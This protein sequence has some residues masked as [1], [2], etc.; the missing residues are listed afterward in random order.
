MDK[1]DMGESRIKKVFLI[2]DSIRIGYQPFVKKNLKDITEVL[3]PEENCETSLKIL[4]NLEN[5]IDNHEFDIV[6]INC[7]LHDIKVEKERGINFIPI[8]SYIENL[9]KIFEFLK[10][11]SNVIIWAKMKTLTIELNRFIDFRKIL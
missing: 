6:H 4:K 11:K 1:S 3:S 8:E 10:R 5:W 2:G 9:K 7:G